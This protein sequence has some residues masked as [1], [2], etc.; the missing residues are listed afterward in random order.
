MDED[1]FSALERF[2]ADE[3]TC[4]SGTTAGIERV[5]VCVH[6]KFLA[7]LTELKA[8]YEKRGE[9][10]PSARTKSQR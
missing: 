10:F 8:E 2:A 3:M 4:V 9:P 5:R 6:C 1:I 7:R